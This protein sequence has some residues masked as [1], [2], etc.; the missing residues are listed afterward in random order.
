[1]LVQAVG[2]ERFVVDCKVN[3]AAFV[4]HANRTL[5]REI[6]IVSCGCG[7]LAD[8]NEMLNTVPLSALPP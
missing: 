5:D 2:K 3:P 1:M 8:P 7:T 4:G 6:V